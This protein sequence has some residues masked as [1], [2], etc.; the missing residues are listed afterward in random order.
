MMQAAQQVKRCLETSHKLNSECFLIWAGREGCHSLLNT[1]IP[2]EMKHFARLL[3]MTSDFKE[4][5]GYRGQLLLQPWRKSDSE[6]ILYN[7]SCETDGKI[8]N[9]INMNDGRGMR[10]YTWDVTSGLCF[11]KHYNLDRH[12][13]ICTKPGYQFYLSST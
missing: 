11:L 13:K 8:N 7:H 9:L 2:K 6:N 10:H 4:R 3:K 5:L 12:Y 1:D